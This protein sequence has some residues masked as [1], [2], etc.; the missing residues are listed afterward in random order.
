MV[1]GKIITM[2]K[3]SFCAEEIQD[4]AIKCRY[5]GEFV[6]KGKFVVDDDKTKNVTPK[7]RKN[8][9]RFDWR[10]I[11]MILVIGCIYQFLIKPWYDGSSIIGFNKETNLENKLFCLKDNGTVRVR[12]KNASCYFDEEV[13]KEIYLDAK[14]NP[15]KYKNFDIVDTPSRGE[16]YVSTFSNQINKNLS[17]ILDEKEKEVNQSNTSSNGESEQTKIAKDN[18]AEVKKQTELQM[19]ELEEAKKQ[20]KEQKYRNQIEEERRALRTLR[21]GALVFLGGSLFDC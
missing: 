14:S 16:N 3:C 13:T 10:W 8:P 15:N 7:K 19:K 18:L 17:T 20:T 4:E 21:C 2:K 5:C 9:N 1:S 11:L 6:V 12:E